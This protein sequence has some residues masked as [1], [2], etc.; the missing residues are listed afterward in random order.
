LIDK[1]CHGSGDFFPIILKHFAGHN[2]PAQSLY[3]FRYGGSRTILAGSGDRRIADGQ[4]G[5]A[6]HLL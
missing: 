5:D 6:N 3:P 1:A 2:R 4:D